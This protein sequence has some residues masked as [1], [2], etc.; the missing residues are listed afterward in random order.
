MVSRSEL[1]PLQIATDRP[2]TW[3]ACVGG[4]L[5][6]E[7]RTI[8]QSK[9]AGWRN[10]REAISLADT[11]IKHLGQQIKRYQ[12]VYMMYHCCQCR[13]SL[14]GTRAGFQQSSSDT[15]RGYWIPVN[16]GSKMS[17]AQLSQMI[18]N[19]RYLWPELQLISV[20]IQWD[21]ITPADNVI[22]LSYR[23]L[24]EQLTVHSL[25]SDSARRFMPRATQQ[26]HHRGAAIY[27]GHR[28]QLHLFRLS[29]TFQNEP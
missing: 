12:A 26:G 2:C 21:V 15:A 22:H 19:N 3:S 20:Q 29:R 9:R 6:E 8:F 1:S 16:V 13:Q 10:W 4:C 23:N 25:I 18:Q 17:S 7:I 28:I 11:S 24:H 14:G 5:A 27:C